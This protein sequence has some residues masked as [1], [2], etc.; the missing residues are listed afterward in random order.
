MDKEVSETPEL[1]KDRGTEIAKLHDLQLEPTSIPDVPLEEDVTISRQLRTRL[2]K[3]TGE[4]IVTI[5]MVL[6]K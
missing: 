2:T 5:R 3:A 6:H 4:E 1:P